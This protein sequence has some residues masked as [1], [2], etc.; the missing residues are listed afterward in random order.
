MCQ[1]VAPRPRQASVIIAEK[2]PEDTFAMCRTSSM[3]AIVP[4]PVTTT[5][6]RDD[7]PLYFLHRDGPVASLAGA[8]L[9]LKPKRVRP[10]LASSRNDEDD[11]PA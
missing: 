5:F 3:G 7:S 8:R 10:V 11:R 4:P 1:T 2:R 9:F 6:M